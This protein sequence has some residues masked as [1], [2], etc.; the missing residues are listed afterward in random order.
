M[1]D[2]IVFFTDC[3]K[4]GLYKSTANIEKLCNNTFLP[5]FCTDAKDSTIN[6][7]LCFDTLNDDNLKSSVD[8]YLTKNMLQIF[9]ESI[10]YVLLTKANHSI[11][12]ANTV[13][14]DER[15]YFKSHYNIKNNIIF[16]ILYDKPYT[17]LCNISIKATENNIIIVSKFYYKFFYIKHKPIANNTKQIVLTNEEAQKLIDKFK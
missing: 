17:L 11:K 14:C 6:Y 9:I 12:F 3:D 15:C 5:N 7:R 2:N 1:S 4:N 10:K 8:I 13:Y 16:K